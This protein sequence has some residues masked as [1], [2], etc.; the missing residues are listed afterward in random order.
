VREKGLRMLLTPSC[1]AARGCITRWRV[2]KQ[3]KRR[4]QGESPAV[5]RKERLT[6]ADGF[7][8][9]ILKFPAVFTLD[10]DQVVAP[11]E[12]GLELAV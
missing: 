11:E 8:E 3:V 2:S 9:R 10:V 7:L 4:I 1:A 6:P 12:A 5:S